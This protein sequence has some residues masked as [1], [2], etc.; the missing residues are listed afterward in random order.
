MKSLYN[1]KYVYF[2]WEDELEGKEGFLADGIPDLKGNVEKG[3][4]SAFSKVRRNTNG[5]EDN[6]PFMTEEGAEFRF[7]YYDPNYEVKKAYAEGKPFQY[8]ARDTGKWC[9]WNY[10]FSPECSFSDDVEY[11]IP[12]KA[13]EPQYRPF[14]D[15][16]ELM[17]TTGTKLIWVV[18]KCCFNEFLITGNQKHA[19]YIYDRWYSMKELFENFTFSDG[20]PCGIKE[21]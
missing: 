12:P 9:Y 13:E 15:F 11:R 10:S 16:N 7:F 3:L 17:S 18:D 8:K 1:K 19:V 2:E 20:S 21:D 4:E 14:E 6:Y 5:N